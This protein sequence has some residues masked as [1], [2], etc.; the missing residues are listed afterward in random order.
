MDYKTLL[1]KEKLTEAEKGE[2]LRA[3]AE[4][5]NVR[6]AYI[7]SRAF[8]FEPLVEKES[9]VRQIFTVERFENTS[10]QPY[11]PIGSK[12]VQMAWIAPGVGNAPRRML[13]G[14][15][16]YVPIFKIHGRV[17]WSMD[18]AADARFALIDE[19]NFYMVEQLK[20]IENIVGWNLIKACADDSNFPTNNAIQ[21]GTSSSI[22][23]S[24]GQGYFSKQL[25]SELMYAADVARRQITD[26]YAS[27][28]T[29]FD[30]FNYWGVQYAGG[31]NSTAFVP[32]LPNGA[33]E[34][35]YRNGT[36]NSG[37]Q[38]GEYVMTLMGVRFHKVYNTDI[39]GNNKVYA[40]DLS[41]AR[42][43]FGVMPIRQGLVT[44]EDPIAITEYKV[45]YFGMM[46]E[47][48]GILDPV[49]M[50]VGTINRP[51]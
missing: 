1:T 12:E 43:K 48:F 10:K 36:P 9:Q 24:T 30:I 3:V 13:E 44:Y 11:Y 49:N 32:F 2:L 41:G 5:E 47:G 51:A 8:V 23:L 31:G 14:D 45:G 19:S 26:I 35:I 50:F 7:K 40:F 18:L 4:D 25:F 33:A 37:N 38:N 22:D 6:R 27:P 29:L 17:E 20:E 28:R 21:I 16:V 42:S 46:R 39:V 15:E 34:E